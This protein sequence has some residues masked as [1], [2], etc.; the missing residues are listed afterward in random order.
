MPPTAHGRREHCRTR[1]WPNLASRLTDA[2]AVDEILISD[3]VRRALAE[4]LD[5]LDA[6]PLGVKGFVEPVR[7]WRLR[8]LRVQL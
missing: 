3:G 4:R 5:C 1:D 8:G 6:G 7:A 2:A